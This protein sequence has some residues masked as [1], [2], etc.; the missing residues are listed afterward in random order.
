MNKKYWWLLGAA[1]LGAIPLLLSFLSLR[2]YLLYPYP[3]VPTAIL[4]LLL[5]HSL[6]WSPTGYLLI[7]LGPV[8]L[9]VS[10]PSLFFGKARLSRKNF[11]VLVIL[12]VLEIVYLVLTWRSGYKYVPGVRYTNLT[13]VLSVVWLVVLWLMF[14]IARRLQ[15]YRV[16]FAYQLL[17]VLWLLMYAFP[18]FGEMP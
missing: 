7:L 2:W 15:S 12:S 18:W 3:L 9:F 10:S 14:S 17:L 1:A 16:V 13:I 4:M 8:L 11:L 6:G 5:M